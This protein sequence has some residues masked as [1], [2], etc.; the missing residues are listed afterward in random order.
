MRKFITTGALLFAASLLPAALPAQTQNGQPDSQTNGSSMKAN[1]TTVT[2][3][4]SAGKKDGT[5]KLMGDDGTTYML[6]SKSTN[7]ADHVGHE[8]TVSGHIMTGQG[9]A[10]NASDPSS[11]DSVAPGSDKQKTQNP[12]DTTSPPPAND[13]TNSAPAGSMR[14]HLMVHSLTMVSDSC[15]T[16]QPKKRGAESDSAPL[17]L[18]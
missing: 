18:E 1:M 8:V 12:N 5:Y 2:G 16:K 10:A 17:Y 4:V 13:A 9:K 7:L 14:S 11:P 3:C 6:R 15:K